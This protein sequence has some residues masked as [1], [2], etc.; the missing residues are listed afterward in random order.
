MLVA[1]GCEGG[2]LGRAA[3]HAL[4]RLATFVVMGALVLVA[5]GD[6]A[7]RFR[8]VPAPE[9]TGGTAY[10][11]TDLVVV[12]PVPALR[13]RE[14]D[15]L[16]VRNPREHALLRIDKIVDSDGPQVHIAGDPASRV[17]QL[18]RTSWRVRFAIPYAGILLGLLAGPVQGALFVVAGLA[19]VVRA[20]MRRGRDPSTEPRRAAGAGA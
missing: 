2:R 7:G 16:I 11:S 20:E 17:R 19:L 6:A 8:L 14:G 1:T 3:R 18:G 12:V 15:V 10:S 5:A 13:L 4:A 9:R